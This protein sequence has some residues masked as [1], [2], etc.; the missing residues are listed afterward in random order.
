MVLNK[1]YRGQMVRMIVSSYIEDWSDNDL[2]DFLR[3]HGWDRD[4]LDDFDY[5]DLYGA[6]YQYKLN[7]YDDESDEAIHDE[8][9]KL[10][11]PMDVVFSRE[12]NTL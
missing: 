10:G 7:N 9:F 5:D 11:L 12:E 4:D 3:E 1:S 2:Y 8:F 6:V